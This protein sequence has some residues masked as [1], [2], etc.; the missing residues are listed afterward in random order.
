M[1]SSTRA[2]LRWRKVRPLSAFAT[3]PNAHATAP[4]A[5][6]GMGRHLGVFSC[7]LLM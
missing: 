6:G 4:D 1:E 7:T 2:G 3:F 5:A